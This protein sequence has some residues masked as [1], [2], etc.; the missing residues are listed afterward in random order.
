MTQCFRQTILVWIPS[1]FLWIFAPIEGAFILR[2]KKLEIPW[3]I[4]NVTR[5][6]VIGICILTNLL[7]CLYSIYR[8]VKFKPDQHVYPSEFSASLINIATFVS[9]KFNCLIITNNLF[10]LDLIRNDIIVSSMVW[11]SCKWNSLDLFIVIVNLWF[12]YILSIHC[13]W[14]T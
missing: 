1:I 13:H 2:S 10:K 3:N 8:F 9:L 14:K 6:I 11:N 7:D 12:S 5:I 4:Y